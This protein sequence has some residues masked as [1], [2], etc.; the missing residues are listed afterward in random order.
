VLADVLCDS[1]QARC[2]AGAAASRTRSESWTTSTSSGRS[3]ELV[4]LVPCRLCFAP[5]ARRCVLVT[6]LRLSCAR[7]PPPSLIHCPLLLFL[8]PSLDSC[9]L[10]IHPVSVFFLCSVVQLGD[11]KNTSLDYKA[12]FAQ[13]Q[14]FKPVLLIILRC[15]CHF[16]VM[17]SSYTAARAAP[18]CIEL[19][20]LP[21][22]H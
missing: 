19:C 15:C 1:S 17:N 13:C 2:G 14:L 5:C 18:P 11:A 7:S 20:K 21:A 8:T 4:V 6:D 9:D 10:R 12:R 22:M 3:G 16:L